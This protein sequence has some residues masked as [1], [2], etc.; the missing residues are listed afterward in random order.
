MEHHPYSIR[1]ILDAVLAGGIRIPAFQRGFVW[2]MGRV[3]YLMDSIYKNYPF[4]SLLFWRTRM[5]LSTERQL[6][7]FK[8]PDPTE[9]YPIDYVLDGQ[10][11]LTSIF[12]VFQADL[13]RQPTAN[14]LDIFFDFKAADSPQE[15][16]FFALDPS[17]VDP[18]RHFPLAVIFES[19]K[20]REATVN[21]PKEDVARID[22]LQEKF[23][24]VQIPVQ[25]LSTEER[26]IV[27]IVF[28]RVNRLGMELDTLQLLSAWT[29]NEDF[30][31][32]ENFDQLRQELSEFGFEEVGEDSNLILRCSAAILTKQ[33]YP[34]KLLELNGQDVRRQFS[35]VSNGI[36][37]AIDFLRKHFSAVHLKN[38]PYPA[39]LIPLSAFFAEPDGKDV[40]YDNVTLNALQRWFWR[41]CF[42]GRYSSQTQKTVARDV[43]AML[44]LKDGPSDVLDKIE[45]KL[46]L[47]FFAENTF[48]ISNAA[49]KTFVL[50]LVRNQPRSLLSGTNINLDQ[51]LMQYNRSEFHHIYPRTFLKESSVPVPDEQINSLSNYCLLSSSENK[52]I[53]GKRPSKYVTELAQSPSLE[54]I[55]QSAFLRKDDFDDDFQTFRNNRAV[56]LLSFANILAGSNGSSNQSVPA[57]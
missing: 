29:W 41:T 51:V 13:P 53:S 21:L 10:Q 19:V 5:K 49:T 2:D 15:T 1:K 50:M 36:K 17:E 28:E 33:P 45:L 22:K 55:L 56:R 39:L 31:L 44:A 11:R 7:Q 34:D 42:S 3:A 48:R 37:G 57:V 52:R 30:D 32:L 6:G 14:W 43:S 35:K 40:V 16:Q 54:E 38:L 4:G 9:D 12:T 27:A 18:V 20:Y 25:V 8:L 26:S 24:E 23:K 47:A 46:T